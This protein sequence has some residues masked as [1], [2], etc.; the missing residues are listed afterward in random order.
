MRAAGP[1]RVTE[2]VYLV[3][4][5]DITDSRDCSVYAIDC[6]DIV[7]ID[8]GAGIST[9][10]I[11]RNLELTGLNPSRLT[12]LVLTH[13]HIDHVGGAAYFREKFG[14]SIVMHDLDARAVERGDSKM[15]A[16]TWYNINLPP[17]PVNRKLIGDVE[18]L[19]VGDGTIVCLHTP[20]HTPG[21]LSLYF[22]DKGER[23]LFGQDIHGPFLAEFGSD[24]TAW[25]ASMEKLLSLEADVLCEG[26]FGVYRPKSAVRR[27]IDSYI[28]QYAE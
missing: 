3:G 6:G 18:L 27:Y 12:T 10:Q 4:S 8:S 19:T 17:L 23:V 7:L 20:G 16:A 21:S 15:T 24:L 11:A 28:D 5:S 25:Q 13:C 14:V 1:V 2:H 26:H 9:S 22:D